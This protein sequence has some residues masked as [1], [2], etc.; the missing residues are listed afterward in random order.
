LVD[1]EKVEEEEDIMTL[2]MMI[3]QHLRYTA[4]QLAKEVLA[5]FE[6]LIPRFVKVFPQDYK[7]VLLKQKQKALEEAALLEKKDAFE[8]LKK[9]ASK[10]SV[11][12]S[13]PIKAVVPSSPPR[14]VEV[15]Y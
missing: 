9:L 15:T 2:R 11:Q 1:L 14:P 4:S 13:S 10:P 12:E 7:R 3:Q 8:E 5:S 6:E